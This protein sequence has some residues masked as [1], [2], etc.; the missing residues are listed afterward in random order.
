[1]LLHSRRSSPYEPG[2]KKTSC[3]AM[4]IFY[5]GGDKYDPTKQH[6][7]CQKQRTPELKCPGTATTKEVDG[8]MLIIIQLLQSATHSTNLS[9]PPFHRWHIQGCWQPFQTDLYPVYA[10]AR[11]RQYSLCI[12][13]CFCQNQAHLQLVV[14]G[15]LEDYQ[16]AVRA[17]RYPRNSGDGL[18]AGRLPRLP[19]YP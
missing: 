6:Y 12:W 19:R 15:V 14:Q 1:M 2:N 16:G 3:K 10:R 8:Q 9:C 17:R 7:C 18:R 4:D 5:R 11:W 13:S